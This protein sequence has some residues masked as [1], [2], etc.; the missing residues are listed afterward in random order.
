VFV[1]QGTN[2]LITES[3]LDGK[4]ERFALLVTTPFLF[5]ISLVSCR[6]L[7]FPHAGCFALP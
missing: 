7:P 5:C 3:V 2:M 6:S 1:A 4:F